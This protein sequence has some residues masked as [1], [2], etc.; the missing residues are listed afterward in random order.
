MENTTAMRIVPLAAVLLIAHSA[1]AQAL[2]RAIREGNAA[3]KKGDQDAAIRSYSKALADQRGVF[4]LGN[5]HYRQDSL[6]D[7]QRDFEAASTLAK[8]PGEQARA[9]HNLGNSRMLQKQWQEAVNA[10]KQALR[11]AP[12]DEDTRYNLA[13][14]QKKLQ[15]EQQKQKQ[16]QQNNDQQKQQQDQQKQDQQQ[17]DQ[18]KQ[19]DQ[20]AKQQ[21]QKQPGQ[22]SKQ[23]AERMLEAMQQQEKA[24]QKEVQKNIRVRP[25]E[26]IEKDW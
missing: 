14:A 7:A 24:A 19:Q 3:Y 2:D 1:T 15:E 26:P 6:T 10:Y 13:Y 18:Q 16:Q 8:S 4:N 25:K 11:R 22:I 9:F 12:G 23:D 20:Q 17:Q 5:A 21:E